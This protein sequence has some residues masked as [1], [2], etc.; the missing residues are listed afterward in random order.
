MME[1]WYNCMRIILVLIWLP[2][3]YLIKQL[4]I[5]T[6]VSIGMVKVMRFLVI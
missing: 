3:V 2:L 4:H 5:H 1:V 6:E